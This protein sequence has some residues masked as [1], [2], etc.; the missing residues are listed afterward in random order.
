MVERLFSQSKLCMGILR[1]R[2]SPLHLELCMYL[3]ANRKV[4]NI[5]TVEE[6]CCRKRTRGPEDEEDD[7]ESLKSGSSDPEASYD[8]EGF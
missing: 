5:Y 4:W 7:D 3:R 1:H 8:E 2:M 6:A